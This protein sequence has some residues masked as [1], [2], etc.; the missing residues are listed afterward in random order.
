MWT[1]SW[2]GSSTKGVSLA[3]SG[4]VPPSHPASAKEFAEPVGAESQTVGT[5]SKIHLWRLEEHSAKPR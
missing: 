2:C 4:V 3:D 5:V 1:R